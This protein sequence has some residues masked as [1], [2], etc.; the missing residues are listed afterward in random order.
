M[1]PIQPHS[2][3]TTPVHTAQPHAPSHCGQ[4]SCAHHVLI[5][6]FPWGP[7]TAN[8]SRAQSRTQSIIQAAQPQEK[9][10]KAPR[11]SRLFVWL[12]G[13]SGALD[14][15]VNLSPPQVKEC[16]CPGLHL[17]KLSGVV[18]SPYLSDSKRYLTP[19]RPAGGTTFHLRRI[20]CLLPTLWARTLHLP[21]PVPELSSKHLSS[22]HNHDE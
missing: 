6:A 5:S 1:L 20:S 12:A 9:H 8:N 11:M 17:L 13:L 14:W 10:Q 16:F 19:P 15:P 21:V 2:G 18:C 3:P 7:L 4:I 22:S